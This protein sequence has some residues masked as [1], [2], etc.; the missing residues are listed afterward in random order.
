MKEPESLEKSFAVR[1]RLLR[2]SLGRGDG[3]PMLAKEF[4]TKLG[5]PA[6]TFRA[7]ESGLRKL[8][9]ADEKKITK[10]FGARWNKIRQGWYSATDPEIPFTRDI[11]VL[12]S[13]ADAEG[14]DEAEYNFDRLKQ[15]LGLLLDNLPRTQYESALSI[16]YKSILG[17][18]QTTLPPDIFEAI[19]VYCVPLQKPPGLK[20]RVE[21]GTKTVQRQHGRIQ[22]VRTKGTTF[23]P[24]GGKRAQKSAAASGVTKP[25]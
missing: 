6:P 15:A 17:M 18:A 7:I 13:F 3:K 24:A 10:V 2:Y 16:L 11:Y 20:P 8:T 5:M 22:R 25:K 12:Y 23:S 19:E 1:M 4:A 14:I 21:P 9:P